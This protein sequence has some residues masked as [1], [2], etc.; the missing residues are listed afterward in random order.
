MADE[1]TFATLE[2]SL[3]SDTRK[4]VKRALE[5]TRKRLEGLRAER[6]R[7]ENLYSYEAELAQGRVVV[8]LDEVGRGPLAGPLTVG[9]V[10]LDPDAEH[11]AGI[12]DSK[13]IPEVK[14]AEIAR[15]IKSK[16]LAYAIVHIQPAEIDECGMTVCLKKAFSQAVA[17]IEE[18]G[19]IPEVI[20]LDG[21]P[22]R[23]DPREVNV[24]KGD[25]KCA[26]ISCASIIAKVER[27]ELMAAYDKDYPGYG[28]ASSKGY[29]S[30]AHRLAIAEHGLT[31]IHR[32]SFCTN[33]L[34]ETL[35]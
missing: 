1:A 31:P 8:G 12:N 13:Q 30:E 19:I 17:K 23:L 6:D 27:D 4:G 20:L 14:R 32:R 9:A 26:S 28:F 15:E 3:K 2:R 25:A 21:N 34:Q 5:Q 29:G 35:F 7:I 10:V 16:C 11:I 24:I 33:F 18:K 22:L